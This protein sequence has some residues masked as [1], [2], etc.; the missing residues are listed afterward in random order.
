LGLLQLPTRGVIWD[1]GAGTG[2]ISIELARLLPQSQI[3][4]IEKNATGIALIQRN[5]QRFGVSTV[6]IVAGRA[7]TAL[8]A[9]PPPQRV[10]LAG[11]GASVAEILPVVSA[12][13]IPAGILVG[14]FATLEACAMTQQFFR[15]L[16]WPLHLL[17][18]HLSRSVEIA[19]STRFS[20][21]NP[22]TLLQ[23]RKPEG[24]SSDQRWRI[25]SSD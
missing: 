12:A 23:A 13:L 7:P 4:A 2:S 16:G 24:D 20:P 21:L 6:Q 15:R 10:V 18:V 19:G 8:A 25:G 1:I 3:F 14:N 9:L 17:Q 11:G 22:V 5:C